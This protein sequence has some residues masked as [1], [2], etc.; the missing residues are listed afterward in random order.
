MAACARA[1]DE[2]VWI[3]M[4]VLLNTNP[5]Q[6]EDVRSCANLSLVM[7]GVGSATDKCLVRVGL[8]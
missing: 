6:D 5:T 4:C 1:H 7:G 2:G 8:G 3:C